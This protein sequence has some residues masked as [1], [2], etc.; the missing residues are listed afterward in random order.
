MGVALGWAARSMRSSPRLAKMAATQGLPLLE[1][2]LRDQPDD[3]TAASPLRRSS[4][5][6]TVPKTRFLR[7]RPHSK[8]NHAKNQPFVR[9]A[10][11]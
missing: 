1:T 9:V 2:A 7:S 4:G 6:S 11:F 3:V 5:F 8:S 10:A